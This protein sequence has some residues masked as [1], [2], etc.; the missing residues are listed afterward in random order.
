M[1]SFRNENYYSKF[2]WNYHPYLKSIK[3]ERCHLYTTN[4]EGIDNGK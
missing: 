3:V 2:R 4:R 1:T